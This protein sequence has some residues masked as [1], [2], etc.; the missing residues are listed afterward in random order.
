MSEEVLK[1]LEQEPKTLYKT[2]INIIIILTIFAWSITGLQTSGGGA[3][4]YI[5]VKNI[6]KGIFSPDFSLINLTKEGI[7]YLL[8]ETIS[9]AFLGTIVGAII[10]IPFAFLSSPNIVPKPVSHAVRILLIFIRTIPTIIYGLIFIRVV[11]PGAYAGLLTMA[12]TSVGMISKLFSEAIQDI[13]KNMVESLSALGMTPFQKIR[14]G[15]FPQ[16][17]AIF[18]STVIYRFDINFRDATVLGLVGAGGIGAPLIFAINGFKWNQAGAILLSLI[19]LVLIIE[20]FSV[21]IRN[22]LVRG[23]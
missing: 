23:Y 10:S 16:L 21:K 6:F 18:L 9:I 3:N 17:Y 1:K 7:P 19:I 8:L 12:V 11:G 2:I 22:K 20:Y 5:I 14:F 15:I 13:N 4:G